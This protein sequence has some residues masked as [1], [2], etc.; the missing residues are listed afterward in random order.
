M[1]DSIKDIQKQY[2]T[3][4]NPVLVMC[5]DKNEY[6]CKYMRSLNPAYKLVCE[7]IGSRLVE[8]WNIR[9]PKMNLVKIK[10]E[11]WSNFYRQIVSVLHLRW[12]I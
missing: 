4:E 10:A 9:S 6:V 11:H 8:K 5:S 7:F 3:G 12:G 2:E 1:L